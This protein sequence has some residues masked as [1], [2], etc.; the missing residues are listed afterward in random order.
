[1]DSTHWS[2]TFPKSKKNETKHNNNFKE[3]LL[4]AN[5]KNKKSLDYNKKNLNFKNSC[6]RLNSLSKNN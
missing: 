2:Y 4:R 1:M 5:S 3:K 6:R